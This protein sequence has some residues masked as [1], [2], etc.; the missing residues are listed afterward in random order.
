[1]L[2]TDGG[3]LLQSAWDAEDLVKQT[4]P[5]KVNDGYTG[6]NGGYSGGGYGE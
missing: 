6:G 4:I 3:F 5:V 1:V 2:L